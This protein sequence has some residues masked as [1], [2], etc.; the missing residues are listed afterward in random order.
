MATKYVYFFGEGK[1]DGRAELK[2]LLGGKG[3]N[4]AEMTNLGIPV[5]PGFTI[6]TEVCTYYY[7]KNCS[8]PAE[9]KAQVDE[10]MARLEQIMGRRFGDKETPLLV[11]VRSG[12]ASS[13][14]GM[15]DTVLNLGLNDETVEAVARQTGDERFAYDCYRRFVA[16]YGD[17]V[18]GLK[19][20]S[21]DDVDPFDAILEE[22]RKHRGVEFDNQ[23]PASDLK[24]LVE[25]Y[26]LLIRGR[27]GVVF[28][29]DPHEQLW[30][31]IS[32]VFGSWNNPRAV[33][34]RELNNIP[35]DMGTAVNVQ[36]MVFGNMGNDCGTGVAFTRNPATGENVFYGEYLINAQGEDVVAGTR[37]P[38]PINQI[39][40]T[41]DTV[42]SLEESMPEIYEQLDKIRLTL[43]RHYRDMQDI[44][45]TIERGKLWMLQTRAGK[46][47]GFASFKIAVDM[48]RQGILTK[49]EALMRVQPEQLNQL[50]RPT[51]DPKAKEDAE[52]NRTFLAKG[53]NAGPGA[54]TGRAVFNAPDAEEWAKRGDRVILVRI[55]TSPED[56]RGMHASQGIL[57]ARGGMTSHAALV[58]R[59]MGKVCVV[60]C[61]AL[62]IDYPKRQM[63]VGDRVIREGDWLSLDGT[64]GEVFMG[65]IPTRPSEIL[66]VLIEKSLPPDQSEVYQDYVSLLSWADEFRRLGVWTN[67][68]Q[69][70]QA[71]EA[72]AF[73]AE[74]IG[75]TRTE[76]MF[77]EG[78]RINA[79]REMILS[80][81]REGRE[82][83]L[84]KLL[85]MQRE[86]FKGLFRVMQQRPVTIRTLDPPLH[87]FLPQDEKDIKKLAEE[88][89]VSYE[90]VA[91]KIESLHELNPMLGH[92][93][94]RLGIV[95]PEITAMQARAI[96]EAACE[97]KKEGLSVHPEVMIPLVGHVGELKNQKQVV[98]TI[99][100][101]VMKDYGV[102]VEYRV[103]TMI[104][105][106]R[107]ALTADRIA[108]VA[109]FFSFGT[110][111]LTQT[112]YG[113]SRDDAGKFLFDYIDAKIWEHDPFERLDQLG[114][115]SLM[116]IAVQKGRGA[117]PDLKI[118]I[119]GEHGGEPT[120]VEF[121]HRLGLDYVSCS[122]YRVPVARLAAAQAA[123]REKKSR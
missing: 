10:A 46:R 16:M 58:G 105:V 26:K 31:A 47:T 83:A 2:N 63:L 122:P 48:V 37:T 123:I 40:K 57:T 45:F 61:N 1:A 73:G 72:L 74:G 65:Q 11:S 81:K 22:M 9:L 32:A 99:A 91:S 117:R 30:G 76:H 82:K 70:N 93:G 104:E 85:P 59:Q 112:V 21:K 80:D 108:E 34:Y 38:Q 52:K 13:M 62:E 71:E 79:V 60:G 116:E 53:L 15:M 25:R 69:P 12:A 95:F 5:P 19:P 6:T 96:L 39:Q 14:P 54:A 17:V 64:T 115:G 113:I 86:D 8:Y 106:P 100:K 120:S 101:E 84:A 94:C 42:V 107:G 88:M 110:N 49:E 98:D 103:G 33:A 67:A 27:K 75:L 7:E 56:I 35:A 4:I 111:D 36:T 50:L 24:D 90:R 121:C 89:G 87:E 43:D 66:R 3:A 119:C 118:G 102:T 44:E 55:E 97:V 114:V 18:L 51:F 29:Q 77:F 28:P 109:E 20:E 68:D 23:L 41:D 92:R 78:N